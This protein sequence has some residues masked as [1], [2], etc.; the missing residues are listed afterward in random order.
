VI[1]KLDEN[2]QANEV[3]TCRIWPADKEQKTPSFNCYKYN[4]YHT[5]YNTKIKGK[6]TTIIIIFKLPCLQFFYIEA[7]WFMPI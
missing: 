7:Y 3:V 6:Y 2:A 5:W 1:N 4:F